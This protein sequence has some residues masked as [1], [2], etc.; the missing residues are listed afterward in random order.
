VRQRNEDWIVERDGDSSVL[1]SIEM[2]DMYHAFRKR[3][4]YTHTHTHKILFGKRN[5]G[6]PR[7]RNVILK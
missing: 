5:E 4:E 2:G 3:Q 1:C 6:R 7:K